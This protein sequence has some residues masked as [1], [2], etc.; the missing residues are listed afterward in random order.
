MF[1]KTH[2]FALFAISVG[3]STASAADRTDERLAMHNQRVAELKSTDPH[4]TVDTGRFQADTIALGNEMGEIGA[5]K[6][7][8]IFVGP[9]EGSTFLFDTETLRMSGISEGGIKRAGTPWDGRHGG[10][11]VLSSDTKTYLAYTRSGP[12]VAISGDWTDPRETGN[13][14]LP[15]AQAEF[16][17]HYRHADGT[18]LH[19][20]AGGTEIFELPQMVDG[21]MVRTFQTAEFTKDL[22]LLVLSPEGFAPAKAEQK[23]TFSFATPTLVNAP[24]GVSLTKAGNGDTVLI[25]PAGT[26]ASTFALAFARDGKQTPASTGIEPKSLIKGGPSLFNKAIAKDTLTATGDA[27]YLADSI[28]LP[29]DNPWNARTRF[30]GFDFFSD[31]DRVAASTWTGDVWIGSGFADPTLSKITWRRFASGMFQTLGLKIVDD[32]IYTLGRDQITRL[33]DLNGDGE[34]D[35]YE[36]FNNDVLITKGF[37][38]FAFDLQTDHDGN[39]Y[40]SKG[41]PVNQGGRGFTEWTE[42]NGA[43]LKVSPDGEKLVTHA[44][45]LRAPG[46]VGVGP[47]G[48]VTTGE[49]EGSYVPR[50]KLT[51]TEP[52]GGSFHGVVPSEWVSSDSVKRPHITNKYV[53]PLEGA[54]TDYTK[55]LCWFPYYVDNSSGSQFWTPEDFAWENHRGA[56]MHLSYGKSSLYRVIKEKV[57]GQIQGGVYKIPVDLTTA[58]MRGR[59]HPLTG[60]LFLAGFR[61]WQTNGGTGIQR[62]RYSGNEKPV[63]LEM[64]AHDNGLVISFSRELDEASANDP[65]RFT[66]TKWDY[67]WG[68]Q[69]GSG[70]FSIDN[71]DQEERDEYFLKESK[72]AVNNIDPVTV[73]ASKLLPDGKS[74]FLYIPDMTPAMQMEIKMDLAARDGEAFQETIW[75]T[76]HKMRSSFSEHGLDLTNLPEIETA[77]LG[78]P[79][80]LLIMANSNANDVTRLSRFAVSQSRRTPSVMTSG[81]FAKEMT[82]S[83]DFAPESRGTYRFRLDGKGGAKLSIAGKVVAEGELPI[84]SNEINLE[85][86]AVP[87]IASVT[88]TEK[89]GENTSVRALWSGEDFVWEPIPPKL[90][91][92][93]AD[94]VENS[95][96]KVRHGRELF[97]SAKCMKCHKDRDNN[98]KSGMPELHETVAG[99]ENAGNR[100][101]NGWLESWIR[102]PQGHC[103]TVAPDEAGDI[104]AYLSSLKTEPLPTV[105]LSTADK[106]RSLAEKMHLTPWM[107]KLKQDARYQDAA[108]VQFLRNPSKH[109]RDTLFPDLRLDE[110]EALALASYVASEQPAVPPSI[111]GDIERGKQAYTKSCAVCH[112]NDKDVFYQFP[113]KRV[114]DLFG[115]DV[116][117]QTEGC[118]STEEG[119]APELRLNLEQKQALWAFKNSNMNRKSLAVYVPHE[120]ATRTMERLNCMSCHSGENKLPVIDLAGEKLKEEWLAS[121]FKG[122]AH[123]VRPWLHARMP[124]FASRADK[125][126]QGL[127]ERAGYPNADNGPEGTGTEQVVLGE[128]IA[129]MTGYACTTCH[130]YGS[131]GAIQAFEGQGP[132]LQF[133]SDR[134]RYGY[135]QS[136]MHWPQRFIPLTIMPKYTIDKKTALNP[137]FLE[138]KAQPQFEAVWQWMKTLEGAETLDIKPGEEH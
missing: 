54:P 111:G 19:Y 96:D 14:P 60:E 78:D 117:W 46:G 122:E 64:K 27:T 45:G 7:L 42:H 12:G 79:G 130:G 55:P 38:E 37:H 1:K 17:G 133:A 120:Y 44:W 49:N 98:T 3:I 73:R 115:S 137:T 74:V 2:A 90:L 135:Y 93:K 10:N 58:V 77:P 101:H 35:Y 85:A 136:W 103:A 61:G 134:L 56:L 62:V 116:N 132:N 20:T 80:V 125:L 18:V 52:E 57:D 114:V 94:T 40:F 43:V 124:A 127:A 13:G 138:G 68:P 21:V 97:A 75:N 59:F 39:F 87:M 107:E 31:G 118:L 33:H 83:A 126:A 88:R 129:G 105:T 34:A 6:G 22:Q 110:E 99:F 69:Y 82:L 50:C 51:W 92:A 119:N 104:A 66:I 108:L 63:P 95:M 86:G 16:L 76:V 4:L 131:T 102:K 25:I 71:F 47:N 72:G 53:G 5:L 100:Y 11:T 29:D 9:K 84:T 30:G 41:M 81:N 106:G 23:L 123:A 67:L 48:E 109:H 32:E 89:S 65:R 91:T 24:D 70:R 36:C 112:D 15:D 113:A 28:G 121:L 8:A 128:K 26:A